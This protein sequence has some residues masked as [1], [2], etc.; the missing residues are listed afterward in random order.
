M[1]HEDD[2]GVN[3]ITLNRTEAIALATKNLKYN[4]EQGYTDMASDVLDD[5]S[6]L[7]SWTC[8]KVVAEPCEMSGSGMLYRP[9]EPEIIS[10]MVALVRIEGEWYV[11]K[12]SKGGL[13]KIA[14]SLQDDEAD[15]IEHLVYNASSL[16]DA[17]EGAKAYLD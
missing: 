11:H 6:T 3:V 13:A 17:L 1:T 16:E 2:F 7:N 15:T 5:I 10:E 8:A 14:K 9:L 12:P 4:V